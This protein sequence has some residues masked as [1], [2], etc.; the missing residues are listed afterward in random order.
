MIRERTT[1]RH[2]RPMTCSCGFGNRCIPE[3]CRRAHDERLLAYIELLY[4]TRHKDNPADYLCLPSTAH[5]N[6]CIKLLFGHDDPCTI[7]GVVLLHGPRP[8]L[9]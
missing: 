4:R 9:R 1:E 8:S 5:E 7:C 6:D 2:I 3:I